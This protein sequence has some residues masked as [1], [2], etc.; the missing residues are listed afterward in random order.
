MKTILKNEKVTWEINNLSLISIEFSKTTKD[1]PGIYYQITRALAS[2]SISI[3]S[4]HTIGSELNIL[5]KN[6][7]FT[8]AHELISSLLEN[9]N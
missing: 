1:T 4:Y 8:H 9:K 6:K 5:I 2:K 3:Q 7:D